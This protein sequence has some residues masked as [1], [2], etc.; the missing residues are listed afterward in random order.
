MASYAM[1]M[2]GVIYLFDMFFV[3]FLD[4]TKNNFHDIVIKII[5]WESGNSA[6]VYEYKTDS[7]SPTFCWWEVEKFIW[8]HLIWLVNT[9]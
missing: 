2:N 5:F 4:Q 1:R 6:Y 9:L 3:V 7:I 8:L